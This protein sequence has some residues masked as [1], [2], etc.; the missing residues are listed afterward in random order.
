MRKYAALV[1]QNA[2]IVTSL[3]LAPEPIDPHKERQTLSAM[4]CI[5]Y[6]TTLQATTNSGGE[7]WGTHPSSLL[8][9]AFCLI[10]LRLHLIAD[11]L[12]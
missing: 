5:Y 4:R 1:V 2:R 12:T 8:S 7:L 3:L 11:L 10:V 6:T 9:P